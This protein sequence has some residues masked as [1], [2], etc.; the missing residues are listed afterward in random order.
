VSITMRRVRA[1]VGSAVFLVLAPGSVA[2]LVPWWMSR[3]HVGAP[4]LGISALRVLGALLIATGSMVVLDSF[5]RFAL[6]GLGTPA[7]V[8]PPTRL[9]VSGSFRYVRNPIYLALVAMILGRG[10]LF[11]SVRVLLY[12]SAVWLACHLFVR[13]YEEPGLRRRFGPDYGEFCAQVPRWIPRIRPWSAH[14]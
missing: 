14:R 2:G 11:G 13:A 9:V 10:L 3:G 7:P 12:G 6:Q 5:A 4:L 8:L 1:A